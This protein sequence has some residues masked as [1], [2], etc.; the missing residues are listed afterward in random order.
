[1]EG[2]AA[3]TMGVVLESITEVFTASLGW[4]GTIADTVADNPLLLLGVVI[5]FIGVGVGLFKR[6]LRL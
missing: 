4:M 2:S 3:L 6:L 1:M 5:P